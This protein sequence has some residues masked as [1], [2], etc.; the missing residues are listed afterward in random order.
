MDESK[1]SLVVIDGKSVFYRGYYAMPNLS[2]KKGLPTGGI[3]GFTSMAIELLKRLKPDHVAVAWDKPKT[4]IR[5]RQSI[6][7]NYKAN[8]KPAPEDFYK[9]IP[10][11]MDLIKAFGW[12]L[13]EFDDYEADDI[14]GTLAYKASNAGI[15]TYLVTSDLDMLQLIGPLVH[16]YVLKTGLSNI[17]LFS[18]ESFVTK[19]GINVSQ[20]LDYKAL[21]G[22]SSDNIPGVSGIGDKGAVA[23]LS[24]FKTLDNIYDNLAL[25]NSKIATKLAEGK[26]MAYLSKELAEIWLDAPLEIDFS[27]DRDSLVDKEKLTDLLNEFDFKS[28]IK[29]VSDLFNIEQSS[30]VNKISNQVELP[31][32]QYILS[33]SDLNIDFKFNSEYL[34]IYWRFSDRQSKNLS[35]FMVKSNK[36]TY[37]FDI[38]SIG[39]DHFIGWLNKYK[40]FEKKI[41]GYDL[42]KIFKFCLQY[43]LKLPTEFHDILISSFLLN[44]LIKDQTLNG[45]AQS[46]LDFETNKFDEMDD[47]L[48]ISAGD[49]ITAVIDKV[50][51]SLTLELQADKKM[52]E[53]LSSMDFPVIP[54]LSKMELTGIKLDVNYLNNFNIQIN[55]MI[56]DLKVEIFHQSGREFNISSPNQLADVLYNQLNIPTA[57][58]KKNKN[59]YSTDSNQLE[60]IINLHPIVIFIVQY[61]EVVKIKNT[62]LDTLPKLVDE[63]SLIHTTYN[64]T[65]AQTGRLSSTD[66]NLQ[67]IPIRT[68]LGKKIRTAFVCEDGYRLISADYSQFELRIA[69]DLA[70]DQEL[71]KLFSEGSYDIHTLTA[72]Q[73]YDC[74]P[75]LVTKDMR[76]AAKTINF[77]I[78]YGMSAH[79][80]VEAT[81]MNYNDANN[82][83]DRY[84][85]IHKALFDYMDS[86]IEFTKK[87]G[88]A[89]TKF[90][91]RRPFKD[92]NSTNFMLRESA[93]RA[94]INMPIQGTE[95]DL[96]KLALI[97]LDKK[98]IISGFD[99]KLVLQIHDSVLIKCRE[100]QVEKVTELVRDTMENITKLSVKLDVDVVVGLNW[101]EL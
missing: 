50:Y 55:Q 64:Q 95:A 23:L 31:K 54:V 52:I 27:K 48:L 81:S 7:P 78:L 35:V 51:E 73:V 20:F 92:I 2:N 65:I 39:L 56:E 80:L 63:N 71:I 4:N 34:S 40:I 98:L 47:E 6:Y 29:P 22:D 25:I 60:K 8:R 88:Y 59:H 70:D 69:A 18:P 9:Q 19:Y 94:A 30:M 96:M 57:G 26:K 77:G 10:Y 100:D 74:E 58:L 12:N 46:Y 91:R 28:L 68:E 79:G 17:E 49:I 15:N 86:I 83:I 87:Y 42:K 82:F 85:L 84:K 66:P 36:I 53:I 67:N 14:M 97:E 16:V 45:L 89:Q 61:R 99:A 13:Y 62:Y 37:V 75:E 41:I 21:K 43:A 3:Y 1:K 76:R 32:K 90:G 33:K 11:L 93:K 101:G 44:P 5:K 24:Q 72:A 38:N